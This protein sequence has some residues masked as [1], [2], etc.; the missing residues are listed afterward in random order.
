MIAWLDRL[1]LAADCAHHARRFM[2]GNG[3]Q[4]VRI[5]AFDEVQVGMAQPAGLCVDQ[6]LMR[7]RVGKFDLADGE[8][9]DGFEDCCLGHQ[10]ATPISPELR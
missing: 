9:A 10:R 3:R 7:G 1:Y 8:R 5:S 2:A 4:R 6:D